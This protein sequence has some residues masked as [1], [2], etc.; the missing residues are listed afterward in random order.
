MIDLN[1]RTTSLM[2]KFN[3][4]V[5]AKFKGIKPSKKLK[6]FFE[7]EF[8]EYIKELNKAIKQI[9]SDRLTKAEEMEWM[10]LFELKKKE[11]NDLRVEIEK[12]NHDINQKV[13]ELYGLS[14]EE[15]EIVE[16]S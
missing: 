13:Y 11:V 7:L 8:G 5:Q 12:M 3:K 14:Q 16:Q 2:D 9:G 1:E 15:I 10:E 4:Y 6:A